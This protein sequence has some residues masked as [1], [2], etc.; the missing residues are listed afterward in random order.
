MRNAGREPSVGF[1]KENGP[2]SRAVIQ[3]IS[4]YSA[5]NGAR[6]PVEDIS[7]SEKGLRGI[8]TIPNVV[9]S[10]ITLN[11]RLGFGLDA[12]HRSRFSK[13]TLHRRLMPSGEIQGLSQ[14]Q[15]HNR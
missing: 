12:F 2:K 10:I 15:R 14:L 3:G 7:I 4:Q 1:E 9:C 13:N 5:S 8:K 11:G 6:W